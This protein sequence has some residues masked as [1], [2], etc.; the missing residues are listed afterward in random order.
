MTSSH[1]AVPP[2]VEIVPCGAVVGLIRPP[3]SK[4]LTNRALVMAALARGP[5]Y[6]TGVLDS[7]D[8]SVMLEAWQKLGIDIE[9]SAGRRLSERTR[10]R[11]FAAQSR[12]GPLYCQ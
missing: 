2:Q 4:S 7:E 3:G 9:G 1:A 10:L 8:T 6:L 12:S 5:S 11:R